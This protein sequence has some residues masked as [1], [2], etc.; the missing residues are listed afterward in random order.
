MAKGYGLFGRGVVV[1]FEKG[2][3]LEIEMLGANVARMAGLKVGLYGLF[4]VV[5]VGRFPLKLV[6]CVGVIWKPGL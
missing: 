5:R 4:G 2:K 6:G 1:I 3:R